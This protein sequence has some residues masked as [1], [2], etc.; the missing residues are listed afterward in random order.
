MRKI[1][2]G[3]RGSRLALEQTR[4]VLDMLSE[5]APGFEARILTIKT[6]GDRLPAEK[7]GE[8][9]G[10]GA[11][12]GDIEALLMKG[13]LDMA[14]HSLKDLSIELD[15][16]LKIGATP[17]R[18][19]ARDA[20]VSAKGGK[21]VDMPSGASV[22]TSSVRRKAQ[23]LSLRRD[24][25]ILDLHG[26]VETRVKRMDELGLDGVVL[27]ASGLDRLSMGEK[28]VQ[29]FS[30]DEMVPA[31]GQGTIAIEI[32]KDD[33]EMGR[34]VSKINDEKTRLASEC[35]RAF[36]RAIGGNCFVPAG[37][38]AFFDG[39]SLALTGMIAS[40][41]GGSILKRSMASSDPIELGKAL[42]EEL[43]QL[44]GATIMK[45]GVM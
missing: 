16:R 41:G 25:R 33:N 7:R 3:T 42:G 22:G 15:D 11:F 30:V 1:R 39:R 20:L 2:V 24:L 6:R 10:K 27:A 19:D 9:D 12:T 36:A 44:G 4:I 5:R 38:Y 29:R 21:L 37:A 45:G 26:N 23:L 40:P 14:V 34:I 35:E 17:P 8:T 32:R 43:L 13:D 18:G 31:A 28:I